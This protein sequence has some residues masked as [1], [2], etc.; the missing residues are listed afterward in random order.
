MSNMNKENTLVSLEDL[1]WIIQ[2]IIK[3]WY[4]FIVF[5]IL[6]G[7]VGVFVSYRVIP[8]YVTKVQILLKSN[9]VYDYQ[10]QINN[11][12][13]FYNQYGDISNQ[14]RVIKSYDMIEQTLGKLDFSVS[15]YIVG[16]VNKKEFFGNMPFK[17]VADNLNNNFYEKPFNLNIV[18]T[19][20]FEISFETKDGVTKRIHNFNEY[21]ATPEY[22]LTIYN[23]GQVN[24]NT[25]STLSKMQYQFVIHTEGYW[26]SRILS[27][28]TIENIE[29]TSILDIS[30]LDEIPQ[31]A[32]IFLDT[33]TST[34]IDYTLQNQF[35]INENTLSYINTQLD[36]VVE[37]LDSIELD[38]EHAR[39][40]KDILDIGKESDVYFNQLM[41]YQ[42]KFREADLNL[43]SLN[44]L[45]NY[46]LNTD[47]E[48]LLPPSYYVLE[49]D[50]YL[51]KALE[52]F[53]KSQLSKI[54]LKYQVKKDHQGLKRLE[55]A[56]QLQKRDIL[57]YIDNLKNAIVEKKNDLQSQINYFKGLVKHIP[58]DERDLL[59]IDRKMQVNEKL[60]MILLEKRANTYIARSGIIPQTKVIERPRNVGVIDG[61]KERRIIFAIIIGV[62]LAVLGAIIR[63]MSFH[64]IQSSKELSE[65]SKLPILGSIPMITKAEIEKKTY[66]SS[67]SNITEALR[68][69]R[70][71]LSYLNLDK[72]S[73]SFI[74]TSTH[75]G[76]GKTFTSSN[77]AQIYAK[78]GK[79]VVIVDF[80]LHKPKVHKS[81]GLENSIG[82]SNF[83]SSHLTIE[84]IIQKDVE[85]NLD[86][87]SSGP[88]PPNASELILSSKVDEL[89]DY[90][91]ANYDYV[92]LDTPPVGYVSDGVVLMN[93]VDGV[94]FVLNTKFAKRKEVQFL[95]ELVEKTQ[96]SN[97][98]LVLNGTKLKKW[99][100]YYGKYGYGYGYGGY[101]YGYGYG[102]MKKKN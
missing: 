72:V 47:E 101:G 99:R 30:L 32:R 48:N 9:E 66:L 59:S 88:V 77:L 69:I 98:G 3:S 76:E 43:E 10:S 39:E 74:V 67:K 33:L 52:S 12:I 60:Y 54:E 100:Y 4:F 8:K 31:R 51:K 24:K 14:I 23:N 21:I 79:K 83:L 41:D 22:I 34:Y 62:V 5:P 17:I 75:P 7:F 81:F 40:V 96:V 38:L 46:I 1:K 13:G 63:F 6:T 90:L 70:T 85:E 93:K 86:V 28:L 82:N 19:E 36:E 25:I 68:G 58:K 94:V 37:V 42:N 65:A 61:N 53:Y 44:N 57:I 78:S 73:K 11:N 64:T 102:S 56:L 80:D 97:V 89:I 55:E 15:Y 49:D 45:K 18:D 92:F 91:N 16:R 2:A 87:I 84:E 29:Y 26:V 27:N 95:E 71:S 50:A 20:T 35:K